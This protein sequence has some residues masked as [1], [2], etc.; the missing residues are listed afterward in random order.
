[1]DTVAKEGQQDKPFSLVHHIT[2]LLEQAG[3]VNPADWQVGL[4]PEALSSTDIEIQ[5]FLI[6]RQWNSL[7]ISLPTEDQILQTRN[8]RGCL[9][10]GPSCPLEDY[11]RLFKTEVIPCAIRMGLLKKSS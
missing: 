5:R 9:M 7:F 10:H 11:L 1:M 6:N 3:V 2:F 8:A 4:S